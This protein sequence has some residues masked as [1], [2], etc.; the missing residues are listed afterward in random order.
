MLWTTLSA[1][2]AATNRGS[3]PFCAPMLMP[4][5]L[6]KRAQKATERASARRAKGHFRNRSWQIPYHLLLLLPRAHKGFLAPFK[7]KMVARQRFAPGQNLVDG[8]LGVLAV[9][10]EVT[11]DG[12]AGAPV[13]SPTMQIERFVGVKGGVDGVEDCAHLAA[14]GRCAVGIAHAQTFELEVPL[15]GHLLQKRLIGGEGL[16]VTARLVGGN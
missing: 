16:A 2:A 6:K 5:C 8:G 13:A 11:G 3:M 15:R 7:G 10:D 1:V 12:G 4:K 9:A 14:G